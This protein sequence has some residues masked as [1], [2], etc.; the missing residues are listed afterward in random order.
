MSPARAVVLLGRISD[1]LYN[2]A[3]LQGRE[4]QIR[5]FKYMVQKYLS[6]TDIEWLERFIESPCLTYSNVKNVPGRFD[7]TDHLQEIN[8][9][10]FPTQQWSIIHTLTLFLPC[11]AYLSI[12]GMDRM[13]D[14]TLLRRL[15]YSIFWTWGFS[16]FWLWTTK[17][18]AVELTVSSE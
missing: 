14:V 16:S 15:G 4:R 13:I 3:V 7:T 10:K 9:R 12:F 6:N 2:R 18:E 1:R 8:K 11:F 17:I 5:V